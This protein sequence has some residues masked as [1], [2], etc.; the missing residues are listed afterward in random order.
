M[1][2]TEI[3]STVKKRW[4]TVIVFALAGLLAG[5]AMAF[6]STKTYTSMTDLYVDVQT[7][8]NSTANELAQGSSAAQLK[9]HSYVDVVSTSS[10]LG[11]VVE[12]LDLPYTAAQL[13]SRVTATAGVN[14]VIIRISVTDTSP[15]EAAR[16]ANAIGK[17]FTTYVVDGLQAGATATTTGVNIKT[18]EPAVAATAPTSPNTKLDV[19]IGLLLGIVAGVAIALLRETFDTRIRSVRDVTALGDAPVIGAIGHNADEKKRALVMHLEPRSPLAEAFRSLRTNLQFVDLEGPARCFVVSSALPAEGKTTTSANLAIALAESGLRVALVDG[20]LR[21]PRLA[22]VMGLDGTVG[23]TDVLIARAELDDV[24]QP[25]GR[26]SLVVL[27][28]GQVP[29]NPSELLGSQ[30]MRALLAD[31]N[32]SFDYVLIDAPPLLPVTDAAVLSRLTS[33]VLLVTAAGKSL[34]GQ[35]K[36]AVTTLDQVGTRV[37]GVIVT[38]LPATSRDAYGYGGYSGGAYGTAPDTKQLPIVAASRRSGN[39]AA[40]K[41]RRA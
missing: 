9:V 12:E 17:S 25:W 13:A 22:E 8:D 3:L 28:A 16:L 6:L 21:R 27:P 23:L 38:M 31:L 19:A 39:R 29:P 14:S 34:R 18:I 30:G 2:L 32:K 41:A 35:F 10:V 36:S 24:L 1:E 7:V 5:G 37:L 11:P 4:I 15:G 40:R 20:D 33:G 26:G